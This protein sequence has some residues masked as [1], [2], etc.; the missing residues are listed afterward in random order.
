ML[1][2]CEFS[3]DL[4]H[5]AYICTD[6]GFS[7][8]WSDIHLSLSNQPMSNQV[9]F[10]S[11]SPGYLTYP[12]GQLRAT[13]WASALACPLSCCHFSLSWVYSGSSIQSWSN[14]NI[15]LIFRSINLR[16]YFKLIIHFF[17]TEDKV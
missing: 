11:I 13:V 6:W 9:P 3:S 1:S 14:R 16:E 8:S 7:R 5:G 10:C 2:L 15:L 12:K 4:T 17:P